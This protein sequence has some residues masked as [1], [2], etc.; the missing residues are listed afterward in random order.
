MVNV[1]LREREKENL[2]EFDLV[3]N[4]T[5]FLRKRERKFKLTNVT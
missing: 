1:Y 3:D 2:F 5:I 4:L